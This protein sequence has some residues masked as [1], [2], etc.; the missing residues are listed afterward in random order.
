VCRDDDEGR[1]SMDSIDLGCAKAS[2]VG[3]ACGKV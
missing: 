2:P 3:I 1:D